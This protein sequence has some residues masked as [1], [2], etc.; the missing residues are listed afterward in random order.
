MVCVLQSL[1]VK[2]TPNLDSRPKVSSGK[3]TPISEMA[4]FCEDTPATEQDVTAKY[5]IDFT[6]TF[7]EEQRRLIVSVQL[8]MYMSRL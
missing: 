4:I 2:G 6:R 7:N 8:L 1:T 3:E 5:S